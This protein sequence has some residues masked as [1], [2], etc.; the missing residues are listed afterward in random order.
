MDLKE[1]QSYLVNKNYELEVNGQYDKATAFSI[2]YFLKLYG[3]D[4]GNWLADRRII[5]AGQL[6][7]LKE[8]IE[9]GP[10][11]GLKGPQTDYAFQVYD[12]R[13][14]G[15]TDTE[16]FKDADKR[17]VPPP[18]AKAQVWPTQAQVSS[19]YGKV[20]ENQTSILAPYP[21]IIAWNTSQVVT[22]ITCHKKVASVTQD[23]LKTVLDHYGLE[24]VRR[25]RLNIFG[26]SLNV[27]KIRGGSG[28]SMHS[29]GIAFDFDPI[30]NQLK[31]N[32]L[33]AEFAKPD[34]KF[35]FETWEGAGAI[36][37]GRSRDYDWMHTQFAR[38]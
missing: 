17:P 7:C 6:I 32:H 37:L 26:G 31:M 27:R 1:I 36:S 16:T 30:N 22:K 5:A 2:G 13:K 10:V 18:P 9:V 15:I 14:K 29:W 19:F 25:L 24:E 23:V 28:W 8:G 38:L 34:Y 33:K 20:G 3:A 4:Y 11:D 12:D 21:L 35:W